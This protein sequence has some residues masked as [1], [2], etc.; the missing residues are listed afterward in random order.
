MTISPNNQS[1]AG[2]KFL[3]VRPPVTLKIARRLKAFLHLE[4]LALEI[5]A[6]GIPSRHQTRIL[7]LACEKSP[8]KTYI[9]ALKE[10]RPDVV[11]F[12][13]YSNEAATV[14]RLA[15]LAKAHRA[16]VVVMVGGVHATLA[17]EDLRLPGVIDLVVRGEGG[18]AM[19]TLV[20]LLESK[21]PWPESSV[22]LPTNSPRFDELAATLPPQLPP[23]EAVPPARLD[24]VDRS[25]Y[26]CIWHGR[27]GERL[28]TLFPRVAAARTSVGCPFRCSFCVVH[29]LARGEYVR[30]TPEDA[31]NDIAAIPE[32]HVY[33][34]DD[35]M[36][37]DANRAGEIARRL[38]ERGVLKHYTSWAR[39]DTIVKH[40]ELF[41]LW[42]EAGLSLVYVGLES[43]RPDI[44]LEYNKKTSPEINQQAVAILRELDIG[45]H[46]SLMLNP[47][48]TEEDIDLVRQAV[49][50]VAP[51]EVSFTVF[52]PSPGTD[53]WKKHRGEFCCPDPHAFYD[54]MHTLLP[55]KMPMKKFYRKLASLWLLGALSNPLLRNKVKVP[56]KDW[57][58]F[59]YYGFWYGCSL[60]F[61]YLDYGKRRRR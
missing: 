5:V 1:G 2:M 59:F 60:Q 12:T 16:G 4:P 22:F 29:H 47:D 31:V 34:L 50:A 35:E 20:P 49:K 13:A 21:A 53:L 19:R 24:L 17:P 18:T 23:Y 25:A 55:T 6:G 30:R 14:K 32:D 10:Y 15:G 38:L 28:P 39:A 27:R 52:S 61:I 58:K 42:K 9:R 36:F 8:E 41:K 43:M 40:P 33:F 57:I 26:Y 11:G 44:L 51:A 3:L 45:L 37:I 54:G 7:D 48:Y 56:L 46:A